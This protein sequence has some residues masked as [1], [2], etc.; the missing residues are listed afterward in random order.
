MKIK[1]KKCILFCHY[2]NSSYLN[3]ILKQVKLTNPESRVILLGDEN[4]NRIA[5]KT[6]VEHYYFKDY[7]NSD[8]I[9]NFEKVYH[10]V[11]GVKHKKEFWTKFVFKRW[12]Y[13]HNFI[14]KNNI[15]SFWHFDSDNMILS[16]LDKQESKFKDF[17]CTE[18]CNGICMNGYITSF[19]VVDGYVNKINN[20]FIDKDYLNEQKLD[21]ERNPDY[22]FTEMRAYKAYKEQENIKSIRLNKI[23]DNESFDDCIC[24]EHG[25]EM[26]NTPL[27]GRYLKKIYFDNYGNFYCYHISSSKYIKM[28]SLNLSWVPTSL[29]KLIFRKFKKNYRKPSPLII[30]EY[31]LLDVFQTKSLKL[32]V[33]RLIPKPIKNYIKNII[34]KF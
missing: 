18:Q 26:Y 10:H 20:L 25:Y 31:L 5:R 17:D 32:K 4:N 11:A 23:I 27:G 15:N 22:A 28:N 33:L 9:L 16:N 1:D 12:F 19:Q 13:I 7:D 29:F 3:Y 14:K 6:G 21:F 30:E 24:Q 34:K 8:E 2:G